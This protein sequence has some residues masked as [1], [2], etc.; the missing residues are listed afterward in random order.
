[1]LLQ[2]SVPVGSGAHCVGQNHLLPCLS[3]LLDWAPS[4]GG[5]CP[6]TPSSKPSAV[7]VKDGSMLIQSVHP[8]WSGEDHGRAGGTGE[9]VPGMSSGRGFVG[10]GVSL[11]LA[12]EGDPGGEWTWGGGSSAVAASWWWPLEQVGHAGGRGWGGR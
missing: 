3:C 1:M 10:K 12:L 7:Q 6:C 9:V 2:P 8:G 11:E 5:F 4:G